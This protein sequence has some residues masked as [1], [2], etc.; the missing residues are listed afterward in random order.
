MGESLKN[1]LERFLQITTGYHV[2]NQ[3][4]KQEREKLYREI[5]LEKAKIK[6]SYE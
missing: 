2:Y 4:Y 1:K 5:K 3:N 6:H